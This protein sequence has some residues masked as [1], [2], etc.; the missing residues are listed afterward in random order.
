MA[1]PTSG[2][3]NLVDEFDEAFMSL[4]EII[5]KED[6]TFTPV[7]KEEVRV[8]IDQCT[9]RFIDIARQLEAFFLQKRF[10]LSALKPEMIIKEEISELR[11]E[12]A[13]KD[14]LIRRHYEKI[15]VWQNLL[16]D[17]QQVAKSPAQNTMGQ[18]PMS[19]PMPSPLSGPMSGPQQQSPQ[20][21]GGM[22]SPQQAMFMQQQQQRAGPVAGGPM[23]GAMLQ[24]PLAYLEKT[25]SNIGIGDG[26][27]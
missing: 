21:P 15:S 13:R 20:V 5:S 27:R 10:L 2:N 19:A 25:T 6:E 23:P 24:G 4:L 26:R 11:L 3:G 9:I 7:D 1:T 16:A 14:D 18:S 22:V 17:L 8:D 12:L